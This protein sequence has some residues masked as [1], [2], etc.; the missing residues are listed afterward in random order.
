MS[1]S[2]YAGQVLGAISVA[3]SQAGPFRWLPNSIPYFGGNGG[4]ITSRELSV[5][6]DVFIRN[7]L[8]EIA[9]QD[10]TKKNALRS[11]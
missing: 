5:D 8:I 9:F 11:L 3:Y 1:G 4:T 10:A 6:S 7:K 2:Q